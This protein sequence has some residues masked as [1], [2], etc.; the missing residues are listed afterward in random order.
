MSTS[1]PSVMGDGLGLA[2][3]GNVQSAGTGEIGTDNLHVQDIIEDM[4]P[5]LN[6]NACVFPIPLIPKPARSS[7]DSPRI[8]QRFSSALAVWCVA[9]RLRVALNVA[10]SP[11][12]PSAEVDVPIGRVGACGETGPYGHVWSRLLVR[13]KKVVSRQA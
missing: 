1:P 11:S 6:Q 7:S 10:W 3:N 2:T 5:H 12:C 9:E 4:R 8:R 13:A